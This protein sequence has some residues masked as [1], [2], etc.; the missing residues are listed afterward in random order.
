MTKGIKSYNDLLQ[1]KQRLESLL[2]AQKQVIYYD[3]EQIKE[4]LKPV[5][6]TFEFIRKITTKDKTSLLL[7][8]GS[9]I[10]INGVVKKFI[11][12]KA[13]WITRAVVP[14]FLKNYSSYFLSEQKDKWIEK[15]KT[16]LSSLRN[17]KEHVEDDSLKDDR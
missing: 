4:E 1:E 16:W 9:D 15:L 7:T 17:G 8:F 10:L 11:L 6:K 12:S 5:R 13:N 14:I 3:I 2:H